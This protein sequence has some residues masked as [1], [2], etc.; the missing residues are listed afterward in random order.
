MARK[1]ATSTVLAR[2]QEKQA[3]L[4]AL[5][6][7]LHEAHRPLTAD[8][9]KA[10]RDNALTIDELEAL[11]AD[12][13]GHWVAADNIFIDGVLAFAP[14]HAVPTTHVE[15]FDLEQRGLVTPVGGTAAADEGRADE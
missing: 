3:A 6:A 12:L 7:P 2:A 14:G 8:E 1:T 15:R 4:D 9:V 13:Y 11:R 10:Q 5:Y